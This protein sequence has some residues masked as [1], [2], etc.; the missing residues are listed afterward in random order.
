MKEYAK[1]A[2]ECM[3]KPLPGVL[4]QT[5]SNGDTLRYDPKT[6]TFGIRR[7]DGGIRT[8]FR[9]QAGKDYWNRE[10]AKEEL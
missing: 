7:K 2:E 4:T 10:I 8:F 5:R 6:N 9:P 3:E 1:A